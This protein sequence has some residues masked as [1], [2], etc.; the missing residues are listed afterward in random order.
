[1]GVKFHLSRVFERKIL[2]I[3]KEGGGCRKWYQDLTVITLHQAC[4]GMKKK[5]R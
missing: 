3:T 4:I 5:G 2:F 1:M